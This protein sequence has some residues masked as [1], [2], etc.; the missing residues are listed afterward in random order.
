MG[1]GPIIIPLCQAIRM[2][3]LPQSIP[4]S[5][6]VYFFL[7]GKTPIYVGKA[8]HLKK[9]LS[10][11]FRKNVAAKIVQLRNEATEIKWIQ[12]D[13]E[14]KAFIKEAELIKKYLPKFNILLRDDK[15]YFY[16]G[17]TKQEFPKVFLTHQLD[18][19]PKN[20]YI[21]PFTSGSALKLT[22][23]LLRRVFPYCTC[24]SP[25]KRPCV[26]A[27]IGR[28]PGYCC[29]KIVPE[30]SRDASWRYAKNIKGLSACLSGGTRRV[31][32]LLKARMKD[33]AKRKAFEEAAVLRD[34]IAGLE[35]IFKHKLILAK[36]KTL[37]AQ[38][39]F[40]GRWI[41]IE[42]TIQALFHFSSPISRVEGYDISN[43]SGTEA[44]GSLVV[45]VNGLPAKSEYRKFRVK[46]V[47]QISDVAMHK[48][49]LRRRLA[50][51]QW[52][53]PEVI[54][55]DGGKPQLNAALQVF[56]GAHLQK[57][58]CIAGL[59]KRDEELYIEGRNLP[60]R[61]ATL[62]PDTMFFFQRV[63]DESHRFA[64]AYHHK[65][66]EKAFQRAVK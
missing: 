30:E 35:N 21:G 38:N 39:K 8:A 65:L 34:Q 10:S 15:N 50:H 44:A 41:K 47:H 49:V 54:L 52:P 55:I 57:R 1:Q 56:R 42:K 64:K 51:A 7:Q 53:L 14:I 4:I 48:E 9:R 45:F 60:V 24:K 23:K 29:L 37:R 3:S 36:D 32:L 19:A 40:A 59:A 25:H 17:I 6:G 28:C 2:I 58:V 27:Q 16:V 66:R 12:T 46:T 26:N 5:P 11:Y 33:A 43:I 61:L 63:R 20:I 31:A 13:S 18:R 22:L 62:P